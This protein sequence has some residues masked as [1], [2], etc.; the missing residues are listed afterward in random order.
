MSKSPRKRA[1]SEVLKIF[2][3]IKLKSTFIT[4]PGWSGAITAPAD[5]D[6]IGPGRQGKEV[7]P[8]DF[9]AKGY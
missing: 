9:E 2:G 3:Q 5:R 1:F 6:F 7:S 4:A 8:D